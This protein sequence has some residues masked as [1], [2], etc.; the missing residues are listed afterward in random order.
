MAQKS[1][2]YKFSENPKL[3]E[4][5]DYMIP[6][7]QAWVEKNILGDIKSSSGG[8]G[9]N[10]Y[11]PKKVSKVLYD[12]RHT[13]IAEIDLGLVGSCIEEGRK[14]G[15]MPPPS[16]IKKWINY[17]RIIPK[18]NMTID[19]LSYV[20]ARSIGKNG[21]KGK[22]YLQKKIDLTKL[23]IE[24]VFGEVIDSYFESFKIIY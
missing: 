9:R 6:I 12:G 5:T 14:A 7:F 4:L 24:E 19:Q 11:Y 8:W 21:T 22:H 16:E 23:N 2:K 3:K 15:K 17:K 13:I 1:L 20:I 18:N 10:T